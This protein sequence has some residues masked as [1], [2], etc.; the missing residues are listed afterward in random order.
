MTHYK[1]FSTFLSSIFPSLLHLLLFSLLL[2]TSSYL[3]IP[4]FSSLYSS[5]TILTGIEQTYGP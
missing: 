3:L 4:L 2:F 5:N 1:L